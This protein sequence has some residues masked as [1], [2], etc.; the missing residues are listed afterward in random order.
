VIN[1]V[2]AA[3]AAATV[4]YGAAVSGKLSPSAYRRFLAGLAKTTLAPPGLLRPLALTLTCGEAV[5]ASLSLVALVTTSLAAAPV[6][7]IL[8]LAAATL[9][10][11]ALAAGVAVVLWRGV[12]APCACFGATAGRELTA[13][14]LAR[15]GFLLAVVAAGLAGTQ[16]GLGRPGPT[17]AAVAAVAG[18]A[19]GL[20]LTRVDDLAELYGPTT[21]AGRPDGRITRPDGRIT[22][23]DGRITRPDGRVT[24]ARPAAARRRRAVDAER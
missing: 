17:Q 9:L 3:L 14:H 12:E 20:I 5:V 13:V 18:A 1:L 7:A 21:P 24:P 22:R 11:V 23:P 6:I 16:M 10:T 19:A 4:V 15:N 2:L 8:A